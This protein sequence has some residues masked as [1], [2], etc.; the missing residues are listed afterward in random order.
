MADN[1]Q[2]ITP[3]AELIRQYLEGKLDDKTMHALEKQALDDPFLAEAL[4]GYAL[5]P[6]DQGAAQHA[7][8]NRLQERISGALPAKGKVRRLDYR[9]L[10]AASVLILLC[11]T[12]VMMLNK[13][14]RKSGEVAQTQAKEGTAPQA[15]TTPAAGRQNV[16]KRPETPVLA[17]NRGL[18]ALARPKQAD[19]RALKTVPPVPAPAAEVHP[20]AMAAPA[21]A[22]RAD[23]AP[24]TTYVTKEEKRQLALAY[25]NKIDTFHVGRMTDTTAY[26]F[27]NR[28]RTF[29]T[30]EKLV[31]GKLTGAAAPYNN[32]YNDQAVR[33]ISGVVLDASTGQKISG[34]Q[35]FVKG[36]NKGIVTDTSGVFALQVAAK[37]NVQLGFSSIGYQ[38]KNVTVSESTNNLKVSLPVSEAALNDVVVVGYG[39]KAKK[40][41]KTPEPVVGKEVYDAYLTSQ[42][43]VFVPG[44]TAEKSGE[45]H[46]YFTVMPDSTLRNITVVKSMGDEADKAAIRILEQGPRWVPGSGRN[47]RNVTLKVPIELKRKE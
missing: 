21:I 18:P 36:T 12:A 43:V 28:A 19:R 38:H 15:D 3:T 6:P 5:H 37:N 24:E 17:D 11:I 20:Q 32:A 34:V 41:I 30:A 8:K 9:W 35:V 16:E 10:A 42:K 31:E 40:K 33:M 44:L 26:A 46:I 47:A 14:A 7:L 1:Q 29:S 25:P 13:P 23:A 27:Q 45:V 39:G 22:K 4:E 2:Y